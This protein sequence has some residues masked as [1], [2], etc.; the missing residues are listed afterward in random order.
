MPCPPVGRPRLPGSRPESLA[1]LACAAGLALAGCAGGASMA[2]DGG[3]RADVAGAARAV[4]RYEGIPAFTPPGPPLDPAALRGAT[5]FEIPITSEVQFI[6]AVEEGMRRAA[7]A[8]GAELVVYPNQGLPSQWAQGI[9]SAVARGADAIT[10]FAQDPALLGPQIAEAEAA[11]VPV[12]VVRTSGE[13]EPCQADPSGRPY[14]SACVPGPFEQA[15]RL[16]ADWVIAESGG[17]ADVL[18]ITAADAR[19][20]VP[21]IRGLRDEFADRCPACRLTEVD[22]PIPDWATRLR[23]EAQ[24]ALVRDP[25]IDWIIPIYDS[26]SQHVVPAVRA[27][28]RAGR[29]R[30]ATFNGTPFVLRE[31]QEGETVSMDA[32]ESLDWVGWATMDQ[33][34]R[35][36]AGRPPAT[37]EGTPLRVFTAENVDE[38]G[39]PPRLDMGYGDAY[40]RGYR[41]LWGVDR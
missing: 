27:S 13:E 36:I 23:G 25:A 16:E 39:R 26:M 28:G 33:A 15:G 24:S 22:V 3:G 40:V 1:A 9:R 30:I 35:L 31:L 17:D 41:R 29:I 10:L 12:V 21:L 32:G 34:F 2:G 7:E 20:T 6:T 8:V 18:V 5:I 11:G 37:S 38:A 19:S 4:A 14:G